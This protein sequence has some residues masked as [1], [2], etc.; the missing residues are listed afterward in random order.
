MRGTGPEE[1][2]VRAKADGRAQLAEYARLEHPLADPRSVEACLRR[3]L[4]LLPVR[5]SAAQRFLRWGRRWVPREAPEKRA[6]R[7]NV[8][9]DPPAPIL[10]ALPA[11]NAEPEIVAP[12]I[13][14]AP[15]YRRA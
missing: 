4:E 6:G 3:E 7:S 9:R 11:A 14:L 15:A 8:A 10:A 13:S 1:L 2:L 5:R 12:R